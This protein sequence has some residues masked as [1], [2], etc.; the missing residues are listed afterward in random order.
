MAA[1]KKRS[2]FRLWK[3]TPFGFQ[4]Y[5]FCPAKV[6]VLPGRSNPFLFGCF[7]LA[8]LVFPCS[9]CSANGF[10]SFD[11]SLRARQAR[12]DKF[13]TCCRPLSLSLNAVTPCRRY[14][15]ISEKSH[16]LACFR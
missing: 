16:A 15:K 11:P 13:F 7:L 8:L 2:T 6:F 1:A 14:I 12:K 5:S 4:K 3:S 9:E 10:V